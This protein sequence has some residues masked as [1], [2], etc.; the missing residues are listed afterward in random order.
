MK[1][2]NME[3]LLGVDPGEGYYQH[4]RRTRLEKL[5]KNSKHA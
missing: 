4:M 2:E 1:A 5:H 3:K